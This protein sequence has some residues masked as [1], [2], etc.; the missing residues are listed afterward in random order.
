[1]DAWL[2][3]AET[4]AVRARWQAQQGLGVDQDF[5]EAAQAYQHALKPSEQ[6]LDAR[7]A[8]GRF[9][10]EWAL[11]RKRAGLDPHGPLERGLEQAEAVLAARPTWAGAQALRSS[12]QNLKHTW[13]EGLHQ[14][15]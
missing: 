9:F 2:Y 6:L 13:E 15:R 14:A 4:R 1:V 3:L 8:F 11:W 5:E 12:L 10:R 7:L